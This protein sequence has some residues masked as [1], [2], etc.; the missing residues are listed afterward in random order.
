LEGNC[1]P[2]RAVSN[3]LQLT[4]PLLQHKT[5]ETAK[6]VRDN[7]RRSRERRKDLL[8][9]LQARVYAYE[10]QGIEVSQEIQRAARQVNE[11]ARQME[12]ENQAL[13]SLLQTVG[14]SEATVNDYLHQAKPPGAVI[15]QVP[16]GGLFHKVTAN[17]RPRL[18]SV[19]TMLNQERLLPAVLDPALSL[20]N[21][22]SVKSYSDYWSPPEQ[23][24]IARNGRCSA[25]T[26]ELPAPEPPIASGPADIDACCDPGTETSC[27]E[28]AAILANMQGHGDTSRA[29]EAL[30]C[31]GQSPC[32]VKNIR[33]FDLLDQATND[34][35]IL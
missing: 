29:R 1:R 4:I 13:R 31:T 12:A 5:E 18:P 22:Q 16:H 28:A 35:S 21:G 34:N 8:Q 30:G 27:E 25:P 19:T 14:V 33:I 15:E 3:H 10:Q 17:G 6:K 7:Q 32:V 24:V 9:E 23:A 11:R 20:S 2:D 26:R